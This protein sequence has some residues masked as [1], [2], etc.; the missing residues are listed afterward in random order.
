MYPLIVHA[1]DVKKIAMQH[2]IGSFYVLAWGL[3]FAVFVLFCEYVIYFIVQGGDSRFLAPGGQAFVKGQE[4]QDYDLSKGRQTTAPITASMTQFNTPG[5]VGGG[6]FNGYYGP[7]YGQKGGGGLWTS[8]K[9]FLCCGGRAFS[10]KIG[11]LK[12]N[13]VVVCF[14]TFKFC[15]NFKFI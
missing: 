3:A 14:K 9:E 1:G 2:M 11:K 7:N 4:N 13:F 12:K 5:Y 6:R 10:A 15:L 8:F